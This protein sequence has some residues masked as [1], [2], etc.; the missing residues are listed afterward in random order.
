LSGPGQRGRLAGALFVFLA[1]CGFSTKS[2][3]IKLA[4]AYGVA[5]STLISLRMAFALPAFAAVALWAGRRA[6]QA[7]LKRED[8]KAI[9]LLGFLGYY[10]AAYLDFIG[11]AYI[12]ATLE[13]LI[14]FLYPTLVVLL[15]LLLFGQ[16]I[17]RRQK[18]AL[19]VSYLGIGLVFAENLRV[20]PDSR[21]TVIGGALVFASAVAYSFY[22]IY[23]ARVVGR[24]GTV[25]FTAY[26]MGVATTLVFAQFLAT[27]SL[28]EVRVPGPVYGLTLAMALFSTVIPAFLMTEGLRLVGA[29]Q[30]A[31][32]GTI[33]PVVTMALGWALLGE[34]ITA[35]QV[36]G[37]ALVLAGVLTVTLRRTWS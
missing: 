2:I 14:L 15:S 30:A 4:Y 3:L 20:G 27:H 11:L 22:L 5:P 35:V 29:N 8:W 23:S 9:L 18:V 16:R 31:T 28:A 19:A 26:A 10:L 21:S 34:H 37:A 7:P 6:S 36:A 17:D 32:I 25:R 24:I 12:P 33:G 13:R 1:A